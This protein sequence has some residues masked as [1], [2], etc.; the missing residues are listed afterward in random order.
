MTGPAE[1][2]LQATANLSPVSPSPV[3]TAAPLVVPALQD[4]VDTIDAMVAAAAKLAEPNGEASDVNLDPAVLGDS[5]ATD[6]V[7]D[8]SLNDP[9]SNDDAGDAAALGPASEHKPDPIDTDDYAKTFDSPIEPD[10]GDGHSVPEQLAE[11]NLE[12]DGPSDNLNAGHV[13]DSVL[14]APAHA[15]PSASDLPAADGTTSQFRNQQDPAASPLDPSAEVQEQTGFLSAA[16]SEGPNP[17]DSA[18][19]DS[20][21]GVDI[22]QLVAD[23][24]S[25]SA[26]PST[27]VDPHPQSG[28]AEAEPSAG[29]IPLTPSTALPSSSSLPPRPP[30][31]VPTSQSFA[32]Q[33]QAQA[34]VATPSAPGQQASL[35]SSATPGSSTDVPPSLPLSSAGGVTGAP[36]HDQTAI[37]TTAAAGRQDADTQRHW[38]QFIT[39]ERQYM[40]EAKWDRF[41]EGSRI[42]IGMGK[43][44]CC[45]FVGC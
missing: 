34:P 33:Q 31:P 32:A 23:L 3:H 27:G 11:S 2:K 24:T 6:A 45:P 39:D 40:S 5:L 28:A 36:Y 17:E 25:Q 30:M 35:A 26:E 15:P 20:D 1:A 19:L 41:P 13:S 8:D 29:S 22:Q 43:R 12:P 21:S 37:G 10:E 9:Y 38:D 7:D 14:D 16:T 44:V 18:M 42:F 4:T